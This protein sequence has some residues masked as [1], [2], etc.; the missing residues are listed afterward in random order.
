MQYFLK[1]FLFLS[2][3]TSLPS[4]CFF[5]YSLT[6]VITRTPLRY[7]KYCTP[8]ENIHQCPQFVRRSRSIVL[9]RPVRVGE[10]APKL[11]ARSISSDIFP[12]KPIHLPSEVLWSRSTP[13]SPKYRSLQ[14]IS[15]QHI[16]SNYTVICAALAPLEGPP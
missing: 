6:S 16:N 13:V 12:T 4:V 11:P 9:H 15:S 2:C 14:R 1:T 7:S 8:Y 5:V 10:L 3:T